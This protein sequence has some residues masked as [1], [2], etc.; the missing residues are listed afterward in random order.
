MAL[1]LHLNSEGKRR[2]P[3]RGQEDGKSGPGANTT[4]TPGCNG[5][6]QQLFVDT[7]TTVQEQRDQACA[8][9]CHVFEDAGSVRSQENSYI[10]AYMLSN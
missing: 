1:G 7:Q 4:S 9:S 3:A 6:Q 2:R 8:A 10:K 5:L